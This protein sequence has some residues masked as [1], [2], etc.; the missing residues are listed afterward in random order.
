MC[1]VRGQ[2]RAGPG[3]AGVAA[4]V[5]RRAGAASGPGGG[6]DPGG[7]PVGQGQVSASSDLVR[8]VT[9][10]STKR[11]VPGCTHSGHSSVQCPGGGDSSGGSGGGGRVPG[12]GGDSGQCSG[13]GE[14]IHPVQH[15]R[16]CVSFKQVQQSDEL[17]S[18]FF[19]MHM[20]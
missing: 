16:N 9:A 7:G 19:A 12:A 13:E 18:F 17:G 10:E 2:G 1:A 6:G 11:G 5:P 15:M 3:G 20:Q 8:P 14:S 4:A